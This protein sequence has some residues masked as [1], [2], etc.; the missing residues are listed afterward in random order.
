MKFLKKINKGFILTV[1]V[2]VLLAIYLVQ[3]E[4]QRNK[5]K[6]DIEKICTQYIEFVNK[7]SA[8]D[9]IDI[10]KSEVKKEYG[11]KIKE[12]VKMF[13]IQNDYVVKTQTDNLIIDIEDSVLQKVKS[14]NRKIEKI[15]KYVFDGDEV[16]VTLK[17]SVDVEKYVDDTSEVVNKDT[18]DS[19]DTITLVKEDGK[20]KI[21]YAELQNPDQD[22]YGSYDMM[23]EF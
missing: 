20:W 12:E 23:T 2:V 11:N 5:E 4:I 7:Y 21:T 6:P 1:L 15:K 10:S 16:T 22:I 9:N 13:L 19:E 3:L 8:Y 14:R 18:Q 17:I